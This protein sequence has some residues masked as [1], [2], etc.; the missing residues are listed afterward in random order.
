MSKV[1]RQF[2]FLGIGLLWAARVGFA[3]VYTIDPAHSSVNFGI[4]HM[5]ISEVQGTLTDVAGTVE[6]D[7]ENLADTKID[8]TI[9]AKSINTHVEA[10]DN[11]L[12]SADFL[13]VEQFPTITFK[14]TMVK[15][16]DGGWVVVGDLTLHGITKRTSFPIKISGP[17][18]HPMDGT[19]VI[20][21]SGNLTIDRQEFGVTWNKQMDNGGWVVGS[22]VK[23]SFHA[24]AK[25]S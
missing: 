23:I 9:Q 6:L 10:R 20:G 11:H 3:D 24:E 22:E 12:R 15:E 14:S 21:L 7:K 25:K 5:M 4:A 17:I 19:M 13:D 1:L 16:Q 8:V 18:T 2:L